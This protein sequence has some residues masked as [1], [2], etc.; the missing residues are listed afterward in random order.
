MDVEGQLP[1]MEFQ[2]SGGSSFRMRKPITLYDEPMMQ[3]KGLGNNDKR[4]LR[5]KRS[6]NTLPAQ[7]R[8][9]F[10]ASI[11]SAEVTNVIN[12]KGR[13]KSITRLQLRA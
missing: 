13:D 6:Q 10:V 1:E 7:N 3:M 11:T 5:F 8:E 2:S 9:D 12:T 4:H